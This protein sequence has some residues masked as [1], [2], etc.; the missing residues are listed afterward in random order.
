[1]IAQRKSATSTEVDVA[2]FDLL[3]RRLSLLLDASEDLACRFGKEDD[4]ASEDGRILDDE[5]TCT[6][7]EGEAIGPFA[8]G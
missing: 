8:S 7:E 4:S 2:L 3:E 5:A 6:R 1:M